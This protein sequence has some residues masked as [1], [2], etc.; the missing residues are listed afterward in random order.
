MARVK[1]FFCQ[2]YFDREKEPSVK[3]NARRYAHKK[4]AENQNK[5]ILQEEIDKENFYKMVKSVYGKNYNFMMIDKQANNYIKQYNYTWS[6]MTACLYWF[7]T[8]NHGNLEEGHGGIGIIPYIY[9]DVKKY[10]QQLYITQ[11]KN[12]NKQMRQRVIEFNIAPPK[13]QRPALHLLNL[14]DE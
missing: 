7:Y 11:N 13:S 1:C 3:I 8:I 5:E 6:G 14:G 2:E 10:Y 9:D 12:S 4:C